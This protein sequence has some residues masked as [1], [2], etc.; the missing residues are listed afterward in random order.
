MIIEYELIYWG[1]G[2]VEAKSTN[3]LF[4][5]SWLILDFCI[6]KLFRDTLA[7]TNTR[8]TWLM[9]DR[10][11]MR[12]SNILTSHRVRLY[13]GIAWRLYNLLHFLCFLLPLPTTATHN[14]VL[15][16]RK[17]K[18]ILKNTRSKRWHTETV[19]PLVKLKGTIK[20]SKHYDLWESVYSVPPCMPLILT[21]QCPNRSRLTTQKQQKSHQARCNLQPGK[22][23]IP[24]V[25]PQKVTLEQ[26]Q[27][28]E[29]KSSNLSRIFGSNG[30]SERENDRSKWSKLLKT[31][32]QNTGN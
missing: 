17:N 32:I 30:F 8:L 24:V 23:T 4:R 27:Q 20:S 5:A 6:I 28:V 14:P 10:E 16:Y 31:Q 18:T 15:G 29:E 1:G 22:I 9:Y 3:R 21:H 12:Y 26:K 19:V 13:R 25:F 7:W 2:V 11:A